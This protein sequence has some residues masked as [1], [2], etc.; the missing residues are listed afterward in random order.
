MGL[1]RTKGG[2][3]PLLMDLRFSTHDGGVLSREKVMAHRRVEGWRV[4]RVY[5]GDRSFN[6]RRSGTA[7]GEGWDCG[8][9][10][11]GKR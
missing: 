3:A 8:G 11:G 1:E 6:S 5:I 9:M 2:D 4:S 10:K 7:S